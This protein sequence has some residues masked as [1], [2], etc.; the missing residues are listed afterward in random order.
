MHHTNPLPF[1]AAAVA[2][3]VAQDC[4]DIMRKR[5]RG[6]RRVEDEALYLSP[7]ERLAAPLMPW[8]AQP[9]QEMLR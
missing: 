7:E 9:L 1:A 6:P 5:R 2:V 3:A 4:S 8:L